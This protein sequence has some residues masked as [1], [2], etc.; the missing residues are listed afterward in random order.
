MFKL[1]GKEINASLGAQTILIW[2]YGLNLINTVQSL[3]TA[4]FWSIGMDHVISESHYNGTILQNNYNYNFFV[5]FHWE[6][7]L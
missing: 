5:K 3:Y 6:P 2:T 1:M 7:Q 4:M